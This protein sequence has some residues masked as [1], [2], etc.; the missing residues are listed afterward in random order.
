MIYGTPTEKPRRRGALGRLSG[1]LVLVGV[2]VGVAAI[3]VGAVL[4]SG[5]HWTTK[6]QAQLPGQLLSQP[7][8]QVTRI[9]ASD[10]KTLITTFFDEDRHDVTLADIAPAMQNALVAAEDV[11]FYQHGGVDLKGAARALV[12]D[13]K[14]G[15]PA[16]GASTLTMQLVRNDLKEDPNLTPAER[17]DATA[18]TAARKLHEVEY[19]IELEQRLSK[20]QILQNYANIVYFGD[21]AYGV[22]A[23][24]RRI[25]GTTPAN[26]DLAQ[27][28]LIAGIIQNPDGDN[29]ISGDKAKARVRQIYVLDAMLKAKMITQQQHDQAAAEKLTFDGQTQPNGCVDSADPSAGW[30]FFCDYL[31]RWWMQQ[32]QF[33]ATAQDRQQALDTGGYTVITSLSPDVQKEAAAQSRSVYSLTSKKT[34]PIAVVQPGTGKVLALA[35]NRHFAGGNSIED[36]ENPLVSGGPGAYGYPTGSTYKLFTMIAALQDGMPLDSTFDAPAQLVTRF[37]DN[38]PQNCGGQYCPRNA[39]PSFMDGERTMWDAYGRS[40]NTYFVHLE[41]Q[42]GVPAAIAVAQKLGV[43]FAAPSDHKQITSNAKNFGSFTLGVTDTTPL[44]LA[45]AYATVASGGTYC[46]PTPIQSITDANGNPVSVPAQCKQVLQPDVAH[47]AA[48]AARCPVGQQSAENTC[49]G[50]TAE[51]AGQ[52]FAG[53]PVAGKTGSSEDNSTESFVG[54]TPTM[55]AAGTAVD[56]ANPTDHVGS[57]VEGKVVVAVAHTLRTAVGNTPYPDFQ[58]PSAALA[59]GN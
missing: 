34:L 28:A 48:D 29:P 22:E 56:P 46:A 55:A 20:Q 45:S 5:A 15:D 40:V 7:A 53:H 13:A 43:S 38:G 26:L 59:F 10:G 18:D 54:F 19:A 37:P 42:V 25:F 57:A 39:T 44:E 4:T 17:A 27:A 51:Q 41:E 52:I 9:Y 16:Q 14:S 23:A 24:A 30:G 3:P 33:G 6:Q 21:G 8:Q 47:A 2:L 50:G 49:D 31:Q 35:V 1:V 11:R 36:T 58:P 12:T 32:P